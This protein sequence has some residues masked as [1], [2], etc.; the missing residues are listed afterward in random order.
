MEVLLSEFSPAVESTDN[1]WFG[2][3]YD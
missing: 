2:G 3:A 1:S